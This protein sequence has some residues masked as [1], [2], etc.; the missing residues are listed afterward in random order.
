MVGR[1][2]RSTRIPLMARVFGREIS[3][4]AA[5]TYASL[6]LCVTSSSCDFDIRSLSLWTDTSLVVHQYA[7]EDALSTRDP[8]LIRRER[9]TY[10]GKQPT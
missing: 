7:L 9:P 3:T 8:S 5:P 1:G 4:V 2:T 6:F 10:R